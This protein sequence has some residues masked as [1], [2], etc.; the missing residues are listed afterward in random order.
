M[1]RREFVKGVMLSGAVAGAP[2]MPEAMAAEKPSDLFATPIDFRYAPHE[3]QSTI[4]FPDDPRKTVVGQ[5]GDLRYSFGKGLTVGMEDF[6]TV[7][8]FSL[9]G[10]E[11]DKVVKQWIEAPGV[12]IVHTI[13]ERPAARFELIAF[14]SR[15]ESEGRV[16]N[17]LLSVRSKQGNIAVAPKTH[18]RTCEK[19]DPKNYNSPLAE[20][21]L[22]GRETPF[23]LAAQV[24]NQVGSWGWWEEA[25]YTVYLP[26]GEAT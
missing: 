13:I 24:N 3:S 21:A 26:H 20:A 23:L 22:S 1:D 8:E 17:V 2:V 16:D 10:F 4:C 5:K 19:L 11:D 7:I 18:I 25:G 9:A 14:A 6:G 12:P 15:H